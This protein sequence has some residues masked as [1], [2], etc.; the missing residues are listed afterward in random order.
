MGLTPDQIKQHR[1]HAQSV[2]DALARECGG[3]TMTHLMPHRVIELADECDRLRPVER[4]SMAMQPPTRERIDLWEKFLAYAND[5]FAHGGYVTS[6][7]CREPRV[8]RDE[9]PPRFGTM[10]TTFAITFVVPLKQD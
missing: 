5:A 7:E 10:T 4:N 3:L 9:Y 1:D 2:L 6:L 8:E